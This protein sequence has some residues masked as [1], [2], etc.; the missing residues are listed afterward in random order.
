MKGSFSL[1][2]GLTLLALLLP[3]AYLL[4]AWPALPE[5]IPSHFGPDGIDGYM[6]RAE[7]WVLTTAL[8]LGVYLL[9]MFLPRFDP[10]RR[11]AADSRSY[12]KLGLLVVGGLGAL[13]CYSVYLGLHPG[14]QPGRGMNV[15]LGLFF[16]ALGNYLSTVPPN[17]FLGLRTPWALESDLVWAKTHRLLGRVFFGGGLAAVLV[18]LF[19]PHGW[20][21]P[22]FLVL[23]LG[24]TVLAYGYSYWLYRQA[25]QVAK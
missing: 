13:A 1:W 24:G 22:A 23:V 18:G 14:L 5:S 12:Q 9:L 4:W 16:A 10:R 19:A 25:L 7:A 21:M 3:T 20:F 17:Y 11:V 6:P 15:G 2:Q 8:P